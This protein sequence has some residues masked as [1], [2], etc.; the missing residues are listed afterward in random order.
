MATVLKKPILLTLLLCLSPFC[1]TAQ[2]LPVSTREQSLDS[3]RLRHVIID[4][5][6]LLTSRHPVPQ[7]GTQEEAE[8]THRSL[9]QSLIFAAEN[10]LDDRRLKASYRLSRLLVYTNIDFYCGETSLDV[11]LLSSF[12][13]RHAPVT[14]FLDSLK[15]QAFVQ[16]EAPTEMPQTCYV[17]WWKE[18]LILA[19]LPI[20]IFYLPEETGAVIRLVKEALELYEQSPSDPDLPVYY[21]YQTDNDIDPPSE[22][23]Y[24]ITDTRNRIG[25][26]SQ[27]GDVVIRPRFAFG[28]PFQNGRA[29][30]TDTGEEKEVEGAHGEY[31]YWESDQ[32]YF[33]DK[34]GKRQ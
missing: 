4:R 11:C 23:F 27:Y 19:T 25:Y 16:F 30:V 28:F 26:M 20:A 8:D 10:H 12:A 14:R 7:R 13:S 15:H 31:H 21:F 29:K 24:R 22:G 18:K 32:W 1:G 33:I 34:T 3:L 6:Y 2:T 17:F 9:M 5:E